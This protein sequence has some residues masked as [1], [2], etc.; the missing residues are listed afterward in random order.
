ME[1]VFMARKASTKKAE[2]KEVKVE[3]VK[4]Y[5]SAEKELLKALNSS[6]K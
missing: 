6:V 1:D 3:A 2:E 4:E 5:L